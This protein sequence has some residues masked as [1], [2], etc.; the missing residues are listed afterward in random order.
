MNIPKLSNSQLFFTAISVKQSARFTKELCPFAR[1]NLICF[2]L[3]LKCTFKWNWHSETWLS[4]LVTLPPCKDSRRMQEG[5]ELIRH[6]VELP[7]N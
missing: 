1:L 4:H 2:F 3:F 6:Y 5:R 7:V